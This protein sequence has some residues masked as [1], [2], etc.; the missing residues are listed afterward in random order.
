MRDND[1]L[2]NPSCSK[3]IL[4]V[5]DDP[6]T[7]AGLAELFLI[8]G[9]DCVA[10]DSYRRAAAAMDAAQPDLLITDI[11]LADFNGLQL[12]IHRP[13]QMP[14]IVITGF[15]DA[16]LQREAEQRG[17]I[18]LVKPVAPRDLMAVIHRLLDAG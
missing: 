7:R 3:R 14:A 9:Y 2:T 6:A 1:T 4:L 12:V 16:V 11:R 8:A 10:V 18:H 5:D 15:P 17:A 13:P